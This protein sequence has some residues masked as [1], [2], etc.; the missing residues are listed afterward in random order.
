MPK[1]R[2]RLEY[3]LANPEFDAWLVEEFGYAPMTGDRLK[4]EEEVTE[5][6]EDELETL[7]EELEEKLK[8]LTK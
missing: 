5:T 4:K 8:R 2:E 3:R 7:T 1:G 6:D